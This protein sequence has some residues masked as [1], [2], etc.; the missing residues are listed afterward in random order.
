MRNVDVQE[1]WQDFF[2]A[3]NYNYSYLCCDFHVMMDCLVRYQHLAEE[4]AVAVAV[5]LIIHL[6]SLTVCVS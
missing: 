4:V 5:Q 1:G 6:N 3:R 2:L